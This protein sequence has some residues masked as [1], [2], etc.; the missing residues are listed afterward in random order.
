MKY[1]PHCGLPVHNKRAGVCEECGKP[2]S[3]SA[4]RKEQRTAEPTSVDPQAFARE[5]FSDVQS[6]RDHHKKM[7]RRFKALSAVVVLIALLFF[8]YSVFQMF[9]RAKN[10]K[11]FKER[12][13]EHSVPEFSVPEFS[14]PE[15]SI[16][17]IS[18]PE[19]AFPAHDDP[20]I[21][22]PGELDGESPVNTD[23][24]SGDTSGETNASPYSVRV[25]GH[26]MTTNLFGENV[27]VLDLEFT[28]N[29]DNAISFFHAVTAKVTQNGSQ[30]MQTALTVDPAL[31][32][33]NAVE[34]GALGKVQ[35]A[36]IAAPE[37]ETQI[38]VSTWYGQQV[39]ME[40]SF[41]S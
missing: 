25:T 18:W 38:T 8:G 30:C 37:T 34:P 12:M 7:L 29:S 5:L 40:D 16:P 35:L 26:E 28:N 13:S 15:I 32:G 11:E 3:G 6:A 39:V 21:P 19:P 2:L 27:L 22:S 17:E 1:C 9:S 4:R 23:E 20:V 10:R 36:F 24:T 31:T 33:V 14:R 41:I